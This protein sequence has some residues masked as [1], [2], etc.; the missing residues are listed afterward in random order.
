MGVFLCTY[1]VTKSR[2][3]EGGNAVINILSNYKN[4]EFSSDSLF[5]CGAG[6]F[7][8]GV[9]LKGTIAKIE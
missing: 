2:V 7:V 3:T 9:A 8:V 6:T 1:S 5:Q 4:K